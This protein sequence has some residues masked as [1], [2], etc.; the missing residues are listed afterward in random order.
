MSKWAIVDGATGRAVILPVG[1][2][3][4]DKLA[5]GYAIHKE[6]ECRGLLEAMEILH[7]YE[8]ERSKHVRLRA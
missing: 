1:R 4:D 8:K 2:L 3:T 7:E 5:Y 6:V